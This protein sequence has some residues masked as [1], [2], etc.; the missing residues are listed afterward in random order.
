MHQLLPHVLAQGVQVVSVGIQCGCDPVDLINR[1]LLLAEQAMHL[2][3]ALVESG[4]DSRQVLLG[5]SELV[6]DFFK[7]LGTLFPDAM[8]VL[9]SVEPVLQEV[10]S[11]IELVELASLVIHLLYHRGQEVVHHFPRLGFQCEQVEFWC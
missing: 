4:L 11:L 5:L 10:R 1:S 8:N 6:V 3:D 2:V 9:Q 7:N